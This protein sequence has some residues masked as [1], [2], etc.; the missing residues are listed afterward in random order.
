MP[1]RRDLAPQTVVGGCLVF[2]IFIYLLINCSISC[3]TLK[4]KQYRRKK[5]WGGR[6][7][8]YTIF[9]KRMCVSGGTN[10]SMFRKF[11]MVCFLVT[12]VS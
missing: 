10:C 12:P 7:G 8:G 5:E 2:F 9:L 1:F 4:R 11:N 3:K 6:Y